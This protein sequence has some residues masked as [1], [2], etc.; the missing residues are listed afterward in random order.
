[1]PK[2]KDAFAFRIFDYALELEKRIKE[3]HEQGNRELAADLNLQ[4]DE[5]WLLPFQR[6]EMKK[7]Y[8]SD[9]IKGIEESIRSCERSLE[10]AFFL[11]ARLDV[12]DKRLEKILK[13]NNSKGRINERAISLKEKYRQVKEAVSS[14]VKLIID[15]SVYNK[16][17]IR[18]AFNEELG[19]RLRLA[20]RKKKYSQEYVAKKLGTSK[21]SYSYYELGQREIPPVYI[22]L[23]ANILD[24]ST[25]YL[26]GTEKK[27]PVKEED[28]PF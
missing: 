3:L 21:S 11:L 13:A 19:I 25:E 2:T 6:N 8:I 20:R 17:V 1:M 28:L 24:V 15:F 26:L 5:L 7:P 22:Y 4:A 27:T 23:L 10:R 9:R 16:R 12:H 18:I 14:Y